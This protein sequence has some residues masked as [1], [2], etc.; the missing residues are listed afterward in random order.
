MT[1]PSESIRP[2]EAP[3]AIAEQTEAEDG[4]LAGTAS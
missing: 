4:R 2:T 1:R 3:G